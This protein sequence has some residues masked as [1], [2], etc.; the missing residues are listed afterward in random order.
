MGEM[1]R[2]VMERRLLKTVDEI[3]LLIGDDPQYHTVVHYNR[4]AGR[5]PQ[6]HAMPQASMA[7]LARYGAAVAQGHALGRERQLGPAGR[8]VRPWCVVES[9]E[10]RVESGEW[11]VEPARRRGCR[12]GTLAPKD[13]LLLM[14]LGPYA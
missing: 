10:W 11:R 2:F 6:V 13:W 4:D 12:E 9:G 5:S 1:A 7:T 3:L 8:F 14:V